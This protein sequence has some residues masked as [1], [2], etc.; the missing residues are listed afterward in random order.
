MLARSTRVCN[1]RNPFECLSLCLSPC[2]ISR[3]AHCAPQQQ[4]LITICL[5]YHSCCMEHEACRSCIVSQIFQGQKFT[6]ACGCYSNF[7]GSRLAIVFCFSIG[8]SLIRMYSCKTRILPYPAVSCHIL[9]YPA[10]SRRILPYIAVSCRI[11][12][13]L[14]YTAVSCFPCRILPFASNRNPNPN[15]NPNPNRNPNLEFQLLVK[16]S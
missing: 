16:V 13:Y 1:C 6:P 7:F 10:V 3:N 12:P 11:L 15:P 8:V 2:E 14:P 4:W 9:P 5:D